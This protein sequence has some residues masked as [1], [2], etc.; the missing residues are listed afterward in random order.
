MESWNVT[1]GLLTAVRFAKD[2][3]LLPNGFE[4]ATASND[5]AVRGVALENRDFLGGGDRVRYSAALEDSGDP[6]TV[7]AQLWHQP[8]SYR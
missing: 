3:R 4:K 7:D 2:N 1:T 5:I 8:I 6:F